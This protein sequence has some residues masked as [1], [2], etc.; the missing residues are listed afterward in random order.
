MSFN[1]ADIEVVTRRAARS[2]INKTLR[3]ARTASVRKVR[4]TYAIRTA[5]VNKHIKLTSASFSDP[6]GI[7]S[8]RSKRLGLITF[9]ARQ[10]PAWPGTT[11]KIRR[12][13]D[14]KLVRSAFIQTANRARHVWM[15]QGKS[16]Y[17]LRLLRTLSPTQMFKSVGQREFEDVA[18]REMP[19]QYE[20]E[21]E[22]FMRRAYKRWIFGAGPSR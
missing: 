2:A 14:R 3:K 11:V 4:Q 17:P 13:R 18:T 19:P 9:S 10:K 1:L 5:D 12:D 15:R 21:I 6:Q 16:R 8:I 20:H 22:F 7:L